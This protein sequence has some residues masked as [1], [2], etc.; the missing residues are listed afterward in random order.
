M[1]LQ[2]VSVGVYVCVRAHHHECVEVIGEFAE[3]CFLLL[4]C[5]VQ[6]SNLS[7]HT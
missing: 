1:L 3:V 5:G 2:D 7:C 6:G 4:P